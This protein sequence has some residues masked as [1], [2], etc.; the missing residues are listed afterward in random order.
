MAIFAYIL[1]G[2]NIAIIGFLLLSSGSAFVRKQRLGIIYALAVFGFA[3]FLCGTLA[4]NLVGLVF[5]LQIVSSVRFLFH[6][7]RLF[8]FGTGSSA[9]IMRHTQHVLGKS[10]WASFATSMTFV[11][12]TALFGESV[13]LAWL[14]CPVLFVVEYALRLGRSNRIKAEIGQTR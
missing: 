12:I 8:S 7:L 10:L 6:D 3:F 2:I 5:A 13:A 4:A 9:S 11:G 14:L 1:T